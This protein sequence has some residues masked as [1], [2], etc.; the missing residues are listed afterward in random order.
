MENKA[1]YYTATGV[2][3]VTRGVKG[4]PVQMERGT[5]S[6][7]ISCTCVSP[8]RLSVQGDMTWCWNSQGHWRRILKD[9][10]TESLHCGTKKK[11]V[12]VQADV[13]HGK[14]ARDFC[15]EDILAV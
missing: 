3:S 11:I 1:L 5:E 13:L 9:N 2:E 10:G 15:N 6:L 14:T 7:V 8:L 12:K 4:G